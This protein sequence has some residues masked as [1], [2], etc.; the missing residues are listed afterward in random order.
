MAV[1][2]PRTFAAS[3]FR[4]GEALVPTVDPR[5]WE[6][7]ET[8]HNRAGGATIEP[9]H[10]GRRLDRA[11]VDNPVAGEFFVLESA[12]GVGYAIKLTR[13]TPNDRS[14]LRANYIAT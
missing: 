8:F 2:R 3:K 10:N 14:T 5:V 7:T 4:T 13:W 12:S 1:S 6:T 9:F 11:S